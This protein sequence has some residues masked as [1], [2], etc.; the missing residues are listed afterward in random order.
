MARA[1][2]KESSGGAVLARNR[3]ESHE[4]L[5]FGRFEAGIVLTG[6]EV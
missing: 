1:S 5:L 2:G 4:F 6:T 3:A